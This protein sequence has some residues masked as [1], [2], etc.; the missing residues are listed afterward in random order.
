MEYCSPLGIPHSEFLRWDED[1]QD[2]ALAFMIFKA[3]LC[4]KCA[5][6]NTGWVD[7]KGRWLNEPRYEAV[8][9][10]CFGCDEIA[11]LE[12]TVPSTAKGTF[13]HA[14]R[15]T[16]GSIP[17]VILRENEMERREKEIREYERDIPQGGYY[18]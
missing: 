14:R 8:T 16:P 13:V 9:Y 15:R 11:N 10:H 1:D 6:K 18:G 5:T 2:K 4:P 7:E 17:E 3:E 12:E